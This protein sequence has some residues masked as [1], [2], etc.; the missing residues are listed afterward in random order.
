[1]SGRL[2]GRV[3][4]VTGGSAG[5]GRAIAQRLA[6]EGASIAVA[7]RNEAIDTRRE[8]EA[9]GSNFLGVECDVSDPAQ[10]EAFARRVREELGGADIVVNNAAIA[11]K[12]SFDELTFEEWQ[13]FFAINVNGY[14]LVAK[15]LLHDL[16]RSN[17]GRIINMTSTSVWLGGPAFTPYVA[18]K[19]AINGFTNSLATDLGQ[20][21]ITV[22]G[23]APGLVRTPA[24]AR[25]HN[26][27][28]FARIV[29][30]QALKREQ[31][32]EDVAAAAAFLASDDAS[33]ITG[34][35]LVVDGGL[36]RR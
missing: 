22:N 14:L 10:V 29:A 3:A 26:D 21:G 13:K 6:A 8:V 23:I 9:A 17:C 33:F 11:S 34:Q 16:K 27:E 24:T 7:D 2:A 1:M 15:A 18:A 12:I 4:V 5:L 28:G 36:T 35:I 32:P 30:M 20:Y 25:I 19:G 31:K